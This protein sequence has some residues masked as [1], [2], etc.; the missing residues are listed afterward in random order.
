MDRE[1]FKGQ[2]EMMLLRLP[3][4]VLDDVGALAK[5]LVIDHRAEIEAVL[6][7]IVAD[8]QPIMQVVGFEKAMGILN[9]TELEADVMEV[10]GKFGIREL[11][12][13]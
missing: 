6:P 12:A 9:T 1:L 7:G 8:V 5:K 10:L 13:G 3:R 11:K 2:L 4:V